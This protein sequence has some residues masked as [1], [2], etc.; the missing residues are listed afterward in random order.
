[1]LQSMGLQRVRCD[2]KTEYKHVEKIIANKITD[3]DCW[4]CSVMSNYLWP[5]GLQ[6]ARLPCPS[7]SPR[8]CSN[9]CPLSWWCHPNI[10]STVA[11]FSSC[12]QSFLAWGSFPVSQLFESGSWSIGASAWASVLTVNIQGWFTLRL[13]GLISLLV[14]GTLKSLLQ[15]HSLKASILPHSAFFMFQ[16]SQ[17]MMR[18][19]KKDSE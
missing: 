17:F 7:P 9:P 10:S 2:L 5:H 3:K 8:V 15:H 16:L 14:Q 19:S 4:Y 13:I 18:N 1:M 11:L 12:C 6:H